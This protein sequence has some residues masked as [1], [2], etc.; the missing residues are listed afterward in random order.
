M[1]KIDFYQLNFRFNSQFSVIKK[2]ILGGPDHRRS[3]DRNCFTS[4]HHLIKLQV[5]IMEIS[6]SLLDFTW[7]DLTEDVSIFNY[8][9]TSMLY[10]R[11]RP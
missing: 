11:I 4:Q 5:K 1:I 10:S 8:Y 2:L 6:R 3:F 7:P 9:V